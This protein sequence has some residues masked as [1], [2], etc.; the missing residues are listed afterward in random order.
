MNHLNGVH[1]RQARKELCKPGPQAIELWED[2][3]GS[4]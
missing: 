1:A 2:T 3:L 4:W